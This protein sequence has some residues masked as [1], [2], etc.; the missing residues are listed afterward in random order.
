M[1]FHLYS[2][3]FWLALCQCPRPKMQQNS[4]GVDSTSPVLCDAEL[5]CD[6][7]LLITEE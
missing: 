6:Q 7:V 3:K 4:G 2:D 5:C 1:G